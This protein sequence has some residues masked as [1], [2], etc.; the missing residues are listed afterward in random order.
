MK[1]F[2]SCVFLL[3]FLVGLNAT[4]NALVL[5]NV[6]GAW[7]SPAG[8][9]DIDYRTDQVSFGNG[10]EQVIQWGTPAGLAGEQSGLGFTGA[11][12]NDVIQTI[13]FGEPFQIGQVRHFNGVIAP[14][15]AVGAVDLVTTLAFTDPDG[16]D[17]K[18]INFTVNE[19][20]NF[21]GNP[22]T[23]SDFVF[24]PADIPDETFTINAETLTLSILGFSTDSEFTNE[25]STPEGETSSSIL[26][27]EIT[28]PSPGEQ[29]PNGQPETPPSGGGGGQEG[30]PI[31]EPTT[32]LLTALGLA[33]LSGFGKKLFRRA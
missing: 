6:D 24:I 26:F 9:A 1:K 10:T 16:L 25:I 29:P 11:A 2:L 19:T 5:S 20:T 23:D 28:T 8:G 32:L 7:D 14:N 3:T 17:T 22:V 15:T 18:I 12:G 33:G 31:P 27:G 4:A 30:A 13:V 21:T